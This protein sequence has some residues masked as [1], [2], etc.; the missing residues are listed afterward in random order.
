VTADTLFGDVLMAPLFDISPYELHLN[1]FLCCT[2]VT[3]GTLSLSGAAFHQRTS[4]T[5]DAVRPTKLSFSNPQ[6][7]TCTKASFSIFF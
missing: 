4:H 3:G 6:L 2:R 1:A 7:T 5:N